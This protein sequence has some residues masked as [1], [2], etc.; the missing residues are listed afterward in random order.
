[1]T[2]LKSQVQERV[3][4]HIKRLG[5]IAVQKLTR[6]ANLQTTVSE[7]D[8]REIRG[9]HVYV[10]VPNFAELSADLT[11]KKEAYRR[12]IRSIHLYERELVRIVEQILDGVVVHFQGPRL[13]AL[14]YRPIDDDQTITT[15]AVLLQVIAADFVS[16]VFNATF[17]G[18]ANFATAS[19]SD[20]GVSIATLDGMRGDRELLFVGS[21]ANY[22]AKI[23]G[24]PGTIA[25]TGRVA[26]GLPVDLNG[27]CSERKDGIFVFDLQGIDAQTLASHY[28]VKWDRRAS[29]ARLQE[30]ISNNP[31]SDIEFSDGAVKLDFEPLSIR[32]NARRD[33]ASLFSDLTGFTAWVDAAENATDQAAALRVM[34]VFR[35]EMA[36]VLRHDYD[37]VRVQYQGDRVQ[38]LVHL[39][40]GDR[41]R[42][43]EKALAIAAGMQS[44]LDEIKAQLPEASALQLTVGIDYGT[45]LASRL[46]ARGRRDRICLGPSVQRAAELEEASSGGQVAISAAVHAALPNVYQNLFEPSG[47]GDFIAHDLGFDKV[48]LAA[49]SEDLY[50]HEKLLSIGLVL[51]GLTV[52]GAAALASQK[53]PEPKPQVDVVPSR[54]HA[55]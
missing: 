25:L 18:C 6:E 16:N 4:A 34:H 24:R 50:G 8:C 1:M 37:G 29:A 17:E 15:K 44:S 31:L 14:F 43:A 51:G 55:S 53:A 3:S 54:T 46:G 49:R 22:A 32:N 39:P 13:H 38:G 12:L 40:N 20:F 35:R 5:P 26:A 33:A 11:L 23:I 21:P 41:E 48:E 9:A 47:F 7:T 19:G 45:V 36:A 10:D 28:E 2:W 27:F 30:D 52:L 42:I